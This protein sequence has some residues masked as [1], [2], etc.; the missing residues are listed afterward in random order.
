MT[1]EIMPIAKPDVKLLLSGGKDEAHQF[2]NAFI[3]S[4]NIDYI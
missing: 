2:F 3:F 1:N 4:I